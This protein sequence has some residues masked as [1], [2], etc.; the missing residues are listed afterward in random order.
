MAVEKITPIGGIDISKS[1]I[2][3]IVGSAAIECYGVVGL[4]AKNSM[5]D[6]V[7]YLLG[8]KNFQEG[9]VIDK[10]KKGGYIIS[11]FIVAASDTKITEVIAEVQKKVKYVLEKTFGIKFNKVNVYV[12]GIKEIN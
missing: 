8:K 1:A 9:I 4:S 6:E 5:K 7:D 2:A 3:S 12:Q 11:L 10:P